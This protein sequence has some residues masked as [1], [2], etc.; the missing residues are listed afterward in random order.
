MLTLLKQFQRESP[1]F[2][3][4]AYFYCIEK[5]KKNCFF[6]ATEIHVYEQIPENFL[7]LCN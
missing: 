6:I 7:I 5:I 4:S 3:L 2:K 1:V